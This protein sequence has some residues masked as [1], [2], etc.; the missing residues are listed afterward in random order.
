MLLQPNLFLTLDSKAWRQS[1]LIIFNKLAMTATFNKSPIIFFIL[2]ILK[3]SK[4]Q[5]S[6]TTK[7]YKKSSKNISVSEKLSS[8]FDN[9]FLDTFTG[10][11]KENSF[12][13]NQ[14][15]L[16]EINRNQSSWYL[17]SVY[18]RYAQVSTDEDSHRTS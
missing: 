13:L 18:S 7:N 11:T 6:K 15:F 12:F 10:L 17:E 14:S 8:G 16:V 2:L 9:Y 4:F 3:F 1:L 5:I